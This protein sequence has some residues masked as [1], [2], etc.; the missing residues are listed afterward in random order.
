MERLISRS[1][2]PPPVSRQDT[3]TITNPLAGLP[4][5][6]EFYQLG[7]PLVADCLAR[8]LPTAVAIV[9]VDHSRRLSEGDSQEILVCA[10]KTIADRLSAA[11]MGQRHLH[12]LLSGDELGMLLVG[13]DGA[14]AMDVCEKLRLEIAAMRIDGGHLVAPVTISIGVAEV[15]GPETFD[16]YLNAAEQFL[17][18]AKSNGGNQTFSDHMIMP[19]AVRHSDLR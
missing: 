3:D 16:N 19:H 14:A 2:A 1:P 7:E 11:S 17:F 12:A 5:L 15:C 9:A 6:T 4:D 8:G 10:L 13:L 18:M